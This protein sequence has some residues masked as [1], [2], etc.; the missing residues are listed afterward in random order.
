MFCNDEPIVRTN[1]ESGKGWRYDG[2]SLTLIVRTQSLE[3]DKPVEV[4]IT[5]RKLAGEILEIANGFRNKIARLKRVAGLINVTAWPNDWSPDVLVHA[6]QTGNRISL[7]PEN[8]RTELLG[9]KS[10]LHALPG[11]LDLLRVEEPVLLK[12]RAH[13]HDILAP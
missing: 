11:A 2:E 6:E 10:D 9:F 12:V 3:V 1:Q 4:R 8:L 5:K 13:L 7:H